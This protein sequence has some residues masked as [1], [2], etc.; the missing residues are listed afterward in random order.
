MDARIALKGIAPP[1]KSVADSPDFE[2][3]VA[4]KPN[5]KQWVAALNQL[6]ST[7]YT[8]AQPPNMINNPEANDVIAG[9]VQSVMLG[10]ATPKDAGCKMDDGIIA[11]LP[12]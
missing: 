4:E 3:W 7:G 12:K 5:R 2:K 10:Q 6:S 8:S 9:G 1:R 11:L